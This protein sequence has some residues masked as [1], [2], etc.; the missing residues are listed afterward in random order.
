VDSLRLQYLQSPSGQK[1]IR[2]DVYSAVKAAVADTPSGD[3]RC[4]MPVILP[5][6]Y[7]GGPRYM[8]KKYKEAMAIVRTH[9]KPSFFVT[10]TCNPKWREITDA[11]EGTGSKVE[12]RVDIGA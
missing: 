6:S 1:K 5:S 2:A 9:G 11:L 12:D 10:I 7:V 8:S 3:V 4:G